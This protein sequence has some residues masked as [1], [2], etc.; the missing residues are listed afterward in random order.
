MEVA[1]IMLGNEAATKPDKTSMSDNTA[2]RN[3]RHEQRHFGSNCA[4]YKEYSFPRCLGWMSQLTLH[5]LVNCWYLYA[6][7]KKKNQNLS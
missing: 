3:R 6:T 2:K 4:W 5:I 7:Y 1:E